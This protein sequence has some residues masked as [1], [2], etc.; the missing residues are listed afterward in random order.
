MHIKDNTTYLVSSGRK[1]LPCSGAVG[2]T[3]SDSLATSGARM[4]Y[5]IGCYAVEKFDGEAAVAAVGDPMDSEVG[6]KG[7]VA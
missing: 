5:L 6:G 2:R 1:I 7:V 3:N 4:V